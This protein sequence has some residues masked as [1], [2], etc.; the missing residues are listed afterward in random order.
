MIHLALNVSQDSQI[1]N[2]SVN[3]VSTDRKLLVLNVI[4]TLG[5]KDFYG[6]DMMMAIELNI[7]LKPYLFKIEL[8]QQTFQA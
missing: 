7:L 4:Q 2:K 8:F 3:K 6:N 5:K 1:D